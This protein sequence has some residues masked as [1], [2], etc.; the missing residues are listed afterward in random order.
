MQ[1]ESTSQN[2]SIFS[3]SPVVHYA[4]VVG[5]GPT[6]YFIKGGR[7]VGQHGGGGAGDTRGGMREAQSSFEGGGAGM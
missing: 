1:G 4:F 2:V 5:Q 6:V 3:V 7:G